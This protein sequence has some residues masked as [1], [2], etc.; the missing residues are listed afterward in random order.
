MLQEPSN[1]P[2]HTYDI[3]FSE[4]VLNKLKRK[5]KYTLVP[6]FPDPESRENPRQLAYLIPRK[7]PFIF[8]VPADHLENHIDPALLHA[9]FQKLNSLKRLMISKSFI[10]KKIIYSNM[11]KIRQ[12]HAT[13]SG[14]FF[15]LAVFEPLTGALKASRP[16]M[17]FDLFEMQSQR[18]GV[19]DLEAGAEG[20]LQA[21]LDSRCNV[22]EVEVHIGKYARKQ[23]FVVFLLNS[24]KV[25]STELYYCLLKLNSQM[26]LKIYFEPNNLELAQP[27]NGGESLGQVRSFR[28]TRVQIEIG[29][30]AEGLSLLSKGSFLCS[31]NRAK[32][33]FDQGNYRMNVLVPSNNQQFLVCDRTMVGALQ[34]CTPSR[35]E[36]S[37]FFR[38]S[39]LFCPDVYDQRE[40][41]QVSP[42]KGHHFILKPNASLE[43]SGGQNIESY[44]PISQGKLKKIPHAFEIQAQYSPTE[45]PSPTDLRPSRKSATNSDFHYSKTCVKGNHQSSDFSHS[46]VKNDSVEERKRT[47]TGYYESSI[48]VQSR[49]PKL[50]R[51]IFSTRNDEKLPK[52]GNAGPK[53]QPSSH[54]SASRS[55]HH[56]ILEPHLQNKIMS[57][58]RGVD[59]K[60]ATGKP[61]PTQ[62]R[63]SSRAQDE[64]AHLEG[65][66]K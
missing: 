54:F 15:S 8:Q 27:T 22:L 19:V 35:R 53:Q 50:Q 20:R 25:K 59:A 65:R 32:A 43:L 13:R 23:R 14:C 33:Q 51:D 30:A 42:T 60:D 37:Y 45:E 66:S 4:A 48:G 7:F 57:N 44:W 63:S 2:E 34:S 38:E 5:K 39:L 58:L 31:V 55:D 16:T 56:L 17:P 1:G 9:T 61:G 10:P 3:A 6:D 47:E 49:I 18:V 52:K 46:L 41:D 40:M 21:E 24:W 64:P 36:H 26:L 28:L 29:K 62:P 11:D 12:G